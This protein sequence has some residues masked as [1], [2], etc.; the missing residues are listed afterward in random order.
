M[1]SKKSCSGWTQ[2]HDIP[3]VLYYLR[4][5][6]G[7]C[8]RKTMIPKYQ[9]IMNLYMLIG[10]CTLNSHTHTHTHTCTRTHK[11]MHIHTHTHTHMHTHT[12]THAHMCANTHTHTHTHTGHSPL[13]PSS[14]PSESGFTGH[15]Q[16]EQRQRRL[17]LS[18]HVL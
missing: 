11:H 4:S 9:E 14:V 7:D 5:R 3:Q 15:L 2:T 6:P 12:Q 17:T 8:A 10:L 16:Q 18:F 1:K 13:L